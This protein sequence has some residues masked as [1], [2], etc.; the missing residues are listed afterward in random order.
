VINDVTKVKVISLQRIV[1]SNNA[2]SK[3]V[4]LRHSLETFL[5]YFSRSDEAESNVKISRGSGRTFWTVR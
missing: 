5:I 2:A 1:R 4:F 3:I